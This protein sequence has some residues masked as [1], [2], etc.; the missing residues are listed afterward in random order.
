MMEDFMNK[1]GKNIHF[2]GIG[3]SGMFPIAKIMHS[4][5]FNVTGSD[6]YDS[7]TL[8]KVKRLGIKVFNTHSAENVK[9]ADVVVYS[10]AIKNDNPEIIFS[11]ELGHPLIERSKMLGI[12]TQNYKNAVSVAGTHGKTTTT[13]MITNILIDANKDPTAIIGGSLRRLDGNSCIGKSNIIVSEACEYVDSFLNLNSEISVILNVDADHL[14]YFKNLEGIEKS[15][16]K[17]AEKTRN[18]LVVN[19]DDSSSMKVIK[20]CNAKKTF[21]S[22]ESKNKNLSNCFYAEN[23]RFNENQFASFDLFY[24]GKKLSEFSLGVPGKHNVYNALAAIIVC[25]NLNV[26]IDD[27]KKSIVNFYGVH[28]RFEFLGT[29]N[30]ITIADDFAHHP[31]EI[32]A[33]LETA[34][35]MNF[36]RVIVIFQPHTYSRTAM[37]FNEFS[38]ALSIATKCII[39]EILPVREENTFN[40]YAEDLVRITKNS[41]YLKTFGEV[42][43]YIL[44]NAKS[45]DLVLTMGGGNIYKCAELIVSSLK[46]IQ[47]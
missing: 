47:L 31:K 17:F 28:R 7:D 10:S 26:D 4:L 36:K 43:D 24:E 32:A 22:V 15:F 40:I 9:N 46:N 23:I 18:L 6:N 3:G 8:E 13:A 38:E 16:E 20:K 19:A 37:F 1:Y 42:C 12:I 34:K 21:F 41:L 11:K 29:Y 35:N 25:L 14:D 2:I 5:G 27:I 33:T 39:T 30:G 45:G 44:K